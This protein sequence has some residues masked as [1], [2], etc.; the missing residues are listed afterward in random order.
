M[1]DISEVAKA[2][3]GEIVSKIQHPKYTRFHMSA[4]EV[5]AKLEFMYDEV[6]QNSVVEL[7]D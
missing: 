5:Y 1:V 2:F 7:E 4:D 6:I 3:I